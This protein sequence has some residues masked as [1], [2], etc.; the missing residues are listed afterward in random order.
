MQHYLKGSSGQRTNILNS[1]NFFPHSLPFASCKIFLNTRLLLV[2]CASRY[3][4]CLYGI[5]FYSCTLNHTHHLVGCFRPQEIIGM[6]EYTISCC[7]LKHLITQCVDRIG[8]FSLR[9]AYLW[10]LKLTYRTERV[11]TYKQDHYTPLQEKL[12]RLQ[13]SFQMKFKNVVLK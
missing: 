7:F 4:E 1:Y 8:S 2:W 11:S 10:A 6:S 12:D 5:I 3:L 13:I 9:V